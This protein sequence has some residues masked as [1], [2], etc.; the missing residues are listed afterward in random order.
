MTLDVRLVAVITFWQ[1]SRRAHKIRIRDG[2][3]ASASIEILRVFRGESSLAATSH[4]TQF[5]GK[6]TCQLRKK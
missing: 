2:P 1:E 5:D 3:A 6:S 4:A